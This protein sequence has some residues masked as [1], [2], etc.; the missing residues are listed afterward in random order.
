MADAELTTI[1]VD[2]IEGKFFIPN[3]QRGYRWD[4]EEV[5][6][7]LDDVYNLLDKT[8]TTSN[9]MQNAKNYCLQPVVVK[10]LGE[11]SFEVIDGQQRLTTIFIIYSYMDSEADFSLSYETREKS[12]D[13]LENIK[14]RLEQSNE[15]IDYYFMANA[16]KTVKNWFDEKIKAD[17]TNLKTIRRNFENL[18]TYNVQVIWYEVNVTEDEATNILRD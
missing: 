5:T 10:K 6:R 7:L 17:S 8:A 13:F 15:N 18:F 1:A 11:K 12:A 14:D 4:T 9:I 3:Y 16:Y 2:K